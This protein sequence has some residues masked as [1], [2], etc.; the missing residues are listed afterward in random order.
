MPEDARMRRIA[1]P[2]IVL[3]AALAGASPASATTFCVPAFHPACPN[4]GTNVQQANLETALSA[5]GSDGQ[6]DRVIIGSHIHTDADSLQATGSDGLEIIGAG[7]GDTVITSSATTNIYVFDLSNRGQPQVVRDLRIVVPASFPDGPGYGAAA[8]I[9]KTT[10]E[11]VEVESRNPGSAGVS[12]IGGG[13]L[14]DSSFTGVSGGTL[15]PAISTNGVVSGSLTVEGAA[16]SSGGAAVRADQPNVPVSIRRTAITGVVS[17]VSASGGGDVDLSDSLITTTTGPALAAVSSTGDD[18]TVTARNATLVGLPGN[19]GQGLYAQVIG[20]LTAG[21]A[22]LTVSD[23]IVRGFP[24]AWYR[25]APVAVLAADANVAIGHSNLTPGGISTGD[26]A[27]TLG[28]GNID[29][30]P[31]FA[32]SG[33]YRLMAGSPSVD[34]GDPGVAL[35]AD[36]LDLAGL[37]RTVNA[38]GAAQAIRDQGAYERQAPVPVPDPGTGAGTPAG[39]GTP[40]PAADTTRPR[41][42]ALKLVGALT[43]RA[44][45]RV[46]LTLSE[47][48]TVT[49]TFTRRVKGRLAR[50]VRVTF[51]GRRAGTSTLRVAK[52]RLAAGRWTLAATAVDPAGNRSAA[53]RLKVKVATGSR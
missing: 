52:G 1:L 39:G 19:L 24:Q 21:A 45:G 12:F 9:R 29:A 40:V 26:G 46:R 47:P 41:I 50:R 33:D 15:S 32:G 11:H 2:L 43:Q 14:R 27:V 10:M 44:G 5:N 13:T 20:G 37:P 49:L 48:A 53:A 28:A 4:D 35:A 3:A 31:L 38:T 30:D 6:A 34:A 7:P 23:S 22:T 25:S 18:S 16:I 51:K 17:G 42:S 36:A 8:Q